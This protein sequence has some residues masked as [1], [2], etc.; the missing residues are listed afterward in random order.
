LYT[1]VEAEVVAEKGIRSSL[2]AMTFQA[3]RQLELEGRAISVT[4]HYHQGGDCW[5]TAVTG[6]SLRR[7]WS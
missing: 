2:K 6:L 5:L 1:A 4:H 3:E 7:G